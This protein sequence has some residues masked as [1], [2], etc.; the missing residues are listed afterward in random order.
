MSP[1]N[2][3]NLLEID[4]SLFCL[5]LDS[6]TNKLQL[7][8]SSNELTNPRWDD[9]LHN[10]AY[11]QCG[12]NRWFDKTITMSV[13][14]NTRLGMMGEHSP[15]DALIPSILGDFCVE[16]PMTV[17]EHSSRPKE[18]NPGQ[19]FRQLVWKTDSYIESEC[20]RVAPQSR[21][22]VEDSDD[23]QLWFEEFGVEWMR[24]G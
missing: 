22:L 5:S 10:T 17:D 20:K 7:D 16:E 4:S 9:H 13:E 6:M 11:G 12:H 14:S 3:M 19:G 24:A 8:S 1:V 18:V 2:Q 15:C 23:S 21:R